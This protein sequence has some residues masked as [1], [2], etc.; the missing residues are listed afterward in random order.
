MLA[1]STIISFPS[2]LSSLKISPSSP[3]NG[4]I[5]NALCI[6]EASIPVFSART[7]AAIPVLASKATPPSSARFLNQYVT[8]PLTTAVFP[9][10]ARPVRHFTPPQCNRLNACRCFSV[11][12]IFNSFCISSIFWSVM[13]SNQSLPVLFN[14]LMLPSAYPSNSAVCFLYMYQ[15]PSGH[16][17]KV[18]NLSIR[19][20]AAK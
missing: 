8:N 2:I 19:T 5:F 7:L 15:F 12:V 9:V 3:S 20:T 13:S 6:V 16:F 14:L 10:P 1:S 17:L 4:T 18:A 11:Y